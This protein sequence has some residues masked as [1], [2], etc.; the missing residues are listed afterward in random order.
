M[1]ATKRNQLDFNERCVVAAF[2]TLAIILAIVASLRTAHGDDS[3]RYTVVKSEAVEQLSPVAEMPDSRPLV[4]FYISPRDFANKDAPEKWH[5][6]PCADQWETIDCGAMQSWRFELRPAPEWVQAVPTYHFQRAD[7]AWWNYPRPTEEHEGVKGF[8]KSYATQNPKFRVVCD[9]KLSAAEP[10]PMLIMFRRFAG[11]SGRITF[12]PDMPIKATLD[13]GT[14]V[15]Y[16]SITGKYDYN[17]G[18]PTLTLDGDK[19]QLSARKFLMRFGLTL[20]DA[21]YDPP[22]SVSV[23]T[24]RGRYT[25]QLKESK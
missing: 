22:S 16:R 25:I 13:D 7:G 6:R 17:N 24:S 11:D 10:D 12:T 2:T 18:R 5:C 3:P 8:A 21:Q 19:P 4:Y 1:K 14:I 9:T 15:S 20:N 23:G